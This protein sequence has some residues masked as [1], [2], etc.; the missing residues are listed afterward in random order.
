MENIIK[1][2]N[3]GIPKCD[4]EM[5]KILTIIF[6]L[7]L[8]NIAKTQA[9]YVELLGKGV[10]NSVNYEHY[11]SKNIQGLNG[12]I[13]VGFAPISLITIPVSLNYVFGKSKHHLEVGAGLTYINGVFLYEDVIFEPDVIA[14]ANIL[15]RYQKPDGKFFFKTGFT[16]FYVKRFGPWFGIGFGYRFQGKR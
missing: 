9:I 15:Y 7:F 14:H 11:F 16:P 6:F 8:A 2:L 1:I 3:V 4:I 5:N 13:G 10:V 12:Q